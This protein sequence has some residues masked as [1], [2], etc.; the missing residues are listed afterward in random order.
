MKVAAG[1]LRQ[2]PLLL[3]NFYNFSPKIGHDESSP[4]QLTLDHASFTWGSGSGDGPVVL[5]DINWRVP[6]G[7]L[8][9]VVGSVGSGKSSLISAA[10]GNFPAKYMY[11]NSTGYSQHVINAKKNTILTL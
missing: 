3:T 2:F 7:A 5:R 9:A 8:V 1:T 6:E 10:L 11:Y 4:D